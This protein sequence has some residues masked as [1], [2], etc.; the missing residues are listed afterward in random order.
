MT[1]RGYYFRHVDGVTVR[2]ST[3]TARAPDVRPVVAFS[4]AVETQVS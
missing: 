3:S 1:A 2:G 4:D